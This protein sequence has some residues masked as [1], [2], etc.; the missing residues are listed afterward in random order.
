[1]EPHTGRS[2]PSNSLPHRG[3]VHLGLDVSKDWIAVGMLRP[4]EQVP[5]TEKVFH[6]EDIRAETLDLD[7]PAVCV[8]AASSGA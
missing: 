4:D 2:R 1:M 7:P 6:D 5:D 8:L 3:V